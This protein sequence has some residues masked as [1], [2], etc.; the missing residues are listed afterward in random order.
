M[1]KVNSLV[2]D[3]IL[4]PRYFLLVGR[5]IDKKTKFPLEEK[6]RDLL[7]L[8]MSLRYVECQEP[9]ERKLVL[10]TRFVNEFKHIKE[11]L[12]KL[13]L[14][15][16]GRPIELVFRLS[17]AA[18]SQ[19]VLNNLEPQDP[20]LFSGG[21]DSISGA[22][23]IIS[24]N[25]KGVLLHINSS[26]SI[27]GKVRKILVDDFF[28]K[29]YTY[30]IDARIKS[31]R[32]R[33][34]FSNTRGLLFLT[35]GYVISKVLKSEKLV[36]C[37]NGAQMLDIM[38][39]SLAY[40]NATATKNTNIKY[41]KAIED[42]F[43]HFEDRRFFVEYP[44][45]NRTKAESISEYLVDDLLSKSWSCYSSRNRSKMCG[46]CWNCFVTKMSALAAGFSESLDFET[47]PLKE[48]LTSNT[49]LDNQRILY[50]MMVFY[51]KVIN[52]DAKALEEISRYEDVFTNSLDLATRFGLDLFLGISSSL[53][54]IKNKNGLGRKAD[55][56]L[57]RI[58]PS[59]ILE[60]KEFLESLSAH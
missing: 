8:I 22:I 35:A 7:S 52:E 31:R 44:L 18:G 55:E 36:F 11:K 2:H 37:E 50:N 39:G 42:L 25:P 19:A 46:S 60:R 29:T 43:S 33:S 23:K 58:D 13:F 59:L 41:L 32:D 20:I 54:R 4:S 24:Q 16:T 45:A 10:K 34:F 48:I 56:L 14:Q 27:F 3:E 38:L 21:V 12:E 17:R 30:C 9:L 51:Q 6:H 40:N 1:L 53:S 49:F 57:S 47:N 5:I 15:L 28:N 26:K